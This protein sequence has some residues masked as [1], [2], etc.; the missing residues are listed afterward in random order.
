MIIPGVK[1]LDMKMTILLPTVLLASTLAAADVPSPE[2][3]IAAAVLAAPSDLRD[4]AAVL[5]YN[6]RGE[7]VKLREGKN[8][9][10]CLASDPNKT[11]FSAACYHRDL[12]PYMARGRELVAQKITGPKRN[13]LRW[14]EVADGK[15]SMPREPRTL[16]VLTGA[17]F[18]APTGKVTDPYLRWVIYVPFATPESTGLSTKASDSAPWLMSPGT[19]GAHIM[20]NP[21]KK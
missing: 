7:L 10:I 19:A 16:Y 14:K 11:A 12:E 4:G 15:L 9:L 21:P 3:Q 20:I 1:G 6:P 13:E 18:D 17:G 8:E 2:V 5:G